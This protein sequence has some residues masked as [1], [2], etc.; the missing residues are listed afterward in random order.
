MGVSALIKTILHQA[1]IESRRFSLQWASAAEAPR[2]VKLV[3]A[4]TDQIRE[5]GPLGQPEGLV[6]AEARERV[7]RAVALVKDV[8]FRIG[9]GK[10]A[11]S[12]RQMGDGATEERIAGLIDQE[13]GRAIAAG[14]GIN[15]A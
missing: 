4:F 15:R 10:I 3:T 11:G 9:F 14:L 13:L 8:R 7:E 6:P 12:L 1:G 5:I 2:F